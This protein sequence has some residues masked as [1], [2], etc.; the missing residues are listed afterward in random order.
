MRQQIFFSQE[1]LAQLKTEASAWL[2]RNP[3]LSVPGLEQLQSQLRLEN[4]DLTFL[5]GFWNSRD[6]IQVQSHE[7]AEIVILMY[8]IIA[9]STPRHDSQAVYKIAGLFLAASRLPNNQTEARNRILDQAV[10]FFKKAE[11]RNYLSAAAYYLGTIFLQ[12]N[13]TEDAVKCFLR[14]FSS[15]NVAADERYQFLCFLERSKKLTEQQKNRL[16]NKVANKSVITDPCFLGLVKSSDIPE[17]LCQVAYILCDY[18]DRHPE[19]SNLLEIASKKSYWPAVFDLAEYFRYFYEKPVDVLC[20]YLKVCVFEDVSVG[21]KE[22]VKRKIETFLS[23]MSAPVS[24]DEE[25]RS[26]IT[27]LFVGV[28]E[29]QLTE[30]NGGVCFFTEL[31]R[32]EALQI[33]REITNG[34]EE[35]KRAEQ[36][37]I[38]PP[39]LGS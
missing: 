7:E 1:T 23:E 36:G 15:K 30:M 26:H 9:L 17:V 5:L 18:N 8:K 10:S 32:Q 28:M 11:E 12:K 22:K 34:I 39:S 20:C 31:E 14:Y 29:K 4:F 2:Q 38:T 27:A 3:E 13:Q 35:R 25:G 33:L 21:F 24:C 6:N 19:I 16:R 37:F